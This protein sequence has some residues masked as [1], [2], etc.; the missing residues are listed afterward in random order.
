MKSLFVKLVAH[1]LVV[2]ALASSFAD[3]GTTALVVH[4]Y[5]KY[6]PQGTIY[7]GKTGL[8]YLSPGPAHDI[9]LG[10]NPHARLALIPMSVGVTVTLG[11]HL[12]PSVEKS[13]LLVE[14]GVHLTG[15]ALNLRQLGE[16]RPPLPLTPSLTN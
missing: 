9:T 13:A 10:L 16:R 15:V 2:L 1:K 4:D 6:P 7:L 11:P 14:T 8:N 5:A 12:K 3:L